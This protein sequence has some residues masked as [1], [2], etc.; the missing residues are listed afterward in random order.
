MFT[1][2]APVKSEAV[3][4]SSTQSLAS[5]FSV[6]LRV[7]VVVVKAVQAKSVGT[8]HATGVVKLAVFQ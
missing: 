6:Q 7:A 5:P 4:Y 3:P 2:V 8:G 1:D